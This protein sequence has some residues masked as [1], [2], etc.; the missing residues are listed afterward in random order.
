MDTHTTA[1]NRYLEV[2]GVRYAYRQFGS[3]DLGLPSDQRLRQ[4]PN[5]GQ[6]PKHPHPLSG[7]TPNGSKMLRVGANLAFLQLLERASKKGRRRA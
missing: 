1:P 5:I 3:Q 6:M 7:P 2:K 4:M